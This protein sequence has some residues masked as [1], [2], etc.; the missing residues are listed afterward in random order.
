MRAG[1]KGVLQMGP[2][3]AA[4]SEEPDNV[5]AGRLTPWLKWFDSVDLDSIQPG[6]SE[7]LK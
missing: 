6:N 4:R 1:G 7:D 2:V 3:E 5:Q